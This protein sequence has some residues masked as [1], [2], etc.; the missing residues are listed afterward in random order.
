MNV[1]VKVLLHKA[2]ELSRDQYVIYGL[3]CRSTPK[4]LLKKIVEEESNPLLS[5]TLMQEPESVLIMVGGK[6]LNQDREFREQ[7][8]CEEAS[9]YEVI[10]AP[11]LEGG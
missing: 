8:E 9:E 7:V 6:T 4:D 1:R 10:I 11:L 3:D 2:L 5:R